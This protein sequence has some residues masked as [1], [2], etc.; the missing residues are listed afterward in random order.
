MFYVICNVIYK[1]CD[2]LD[3]FGNFDEQLDMMEMIKCNLF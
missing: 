2:F 3:V 1:W